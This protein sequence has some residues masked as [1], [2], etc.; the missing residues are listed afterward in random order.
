MDRSTAA[1]VCLYGAAMT[2]MVR[3]RAAL[4]LCLIAGSAAAFESRPPVQAEKQMVVA[5]NPLAAGT[6]LEML[7]QGGTAVDAAVA[8]QMVLTLVEP[9][10]SGIG[11]GGF[12]LHYDA[13][14]QKLT[15][16]NGRET[17]PS[18]ATPDMFL[19]ADGTPM[20]FDEAVVGGLSVGVP[21]AL[22][23]LEL[24]HREHGRLPWP[25]LFEPAIRLAEEGFAVSP[26][27]HALLA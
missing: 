8:V 11:G 9:Q 20:E 17:A 5:A 4:T 6:G 21:G 25:R 3:L 24:T 7:R 22:R 15:A 1:E 14:A 26:R 13:E 2:W 18:A 16:Y 19:H 23:L 27:L 10:S 12:L